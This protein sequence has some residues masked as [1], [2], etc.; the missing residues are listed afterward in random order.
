MLFAPGTIAAKKSGFRGWALAL[1]WLDIRCTLRV[2]CRLQAVLN[3]LRS[4]AFSASGPILP[5]L[6][7]AFLSTVD[8]LP[9]PLAGSSSPPAFGLRASTRGCS[10]EPGDMWDET[11]SRS[12]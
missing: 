8:G 1:A 12:P 4:L 7:L 6:G 3:F 10:I 9:I 11:V 5:V 2:R